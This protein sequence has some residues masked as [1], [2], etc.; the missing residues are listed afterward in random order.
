MSHEGPLLLV[1]RHVTI[2]KHSARSPA[3][4]EWTSAST[5]VGKDDD[6]LA[7]WCGN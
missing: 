5:T 3:L 7:R 6:C 2:R 1:L 4:E